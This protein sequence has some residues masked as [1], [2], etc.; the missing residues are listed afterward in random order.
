L[1][2][3][4]RSQPL[5]KML[6]HF[7]RSLMLQISQ[8]AVCFRF[9]QIQERLAR[10][11]LLS[12]DRMDSTEFRMTQEY[13]SLMLGVRREGVTKAASHLQ[14]LG[15]IKYSRGRIQILDRPRLEAASCACYAILAKQM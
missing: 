14:K 13:W 2:E 12:A 8:C 7:T 4:A 5:T 15:I 11:L 10:W 3:C 6:L 9:H 1:E